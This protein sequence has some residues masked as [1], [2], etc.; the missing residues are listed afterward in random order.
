MFVGNPIIK[1]RGLG[2]ADFV[3][4]SL[5]VLASSPYSC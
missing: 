4:F 5:G 1:S 3:H 2:A